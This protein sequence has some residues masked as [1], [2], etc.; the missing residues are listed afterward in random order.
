MDHCGGQ[1]GSWTRER[2]RVQF[3]MFVIFMT[4]E[5][6]FLFVE[7]KHLLNTFS[8]LDTIGNI[9]QQD[10]ELKGSQSGL[11]NNVQPRGNNQK[12]ESFRLSLI[13]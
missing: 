5:D 6:V 13:V 2:L 1:L 4:I 11:R 3:N 9:G 8:V 10:P 7:L 12:T